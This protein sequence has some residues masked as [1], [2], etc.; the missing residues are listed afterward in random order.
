MEREKPL[1][2]MAFLGCAITMVSVLLILVINLYLE[3]KSGAIYRSQP[4]ANLVGIVLLILGLILTYI[5][6]K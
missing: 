2:L 4:L 1:R 3:D 5:G 6:L